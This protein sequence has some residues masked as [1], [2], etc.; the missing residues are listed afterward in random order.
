M[1]SRSESEFWSVSRALLS[2]LTCANNTG[3]ETASL[4][5][6]S[7]ELRNKL[8]NFAIVGGG[9]KGSFHYPW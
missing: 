5:T 7:P 4:P 6:T 3:F 9:R 8:L 1:P 2:P